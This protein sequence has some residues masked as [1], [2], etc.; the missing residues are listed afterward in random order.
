[1]LQDKDVVVTI[2]VKDLGTAKKFY[3]DTLELEPID[4]EGEEVVTF[5]SGKSTINIYRSQYAGSNKA[6]AATWTV[7]EDLEGVVQA[8]KKKGIKFEQY[9]LPGMKREGDIHVGGDIRT[10]W[11]KDP[12]GNILNIINR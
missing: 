5:K 1:M 4:A 7:G 9:D 11:F 6:T 12:D 3:A 10:A 8:L 2:A